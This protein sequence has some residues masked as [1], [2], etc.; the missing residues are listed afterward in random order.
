MK[1][2]EDEISQID[3]GPLTL[4]VLEANMNNPCEPECK[5]DQRLEN[6]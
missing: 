6:G 4:H 1:N 3:L 5:P 2:Y